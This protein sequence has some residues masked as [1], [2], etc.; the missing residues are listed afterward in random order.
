MEARTPL[1]FCFFCYTIPFAKHVGKG[2][3][4]PCDE[5]EIKRWGVNEGFAKILAHHL[6]ASEPRSPSA[7]NVTDIIAGT[8]CSSLGTSTGAAGCAHD[9]GNLV[10]KAY[11]KIVE[12]QGADY[13]YEVYLE[14]LGRLKGGE[15]TP[16]T[17]HKEV[18]EVMVERHAPAPLMLMSPMPLDPDP[19]ALLDWLWVLWWWGIPVDFIV[20]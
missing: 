4:L 16:A 5:A 2:C 18:R 20:D 3:V 7:D 15:V 10:F 8:G 6:T 19:F 13:A 11:E 17:L 1:A 9:L 12:G 14:A